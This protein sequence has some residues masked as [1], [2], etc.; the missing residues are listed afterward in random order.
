MLVS[1]QVQLALLCVLFNPDQVHLNC[2]YFLCFV[3]LRPGS[4]NL[5][6]CVG[7]LMSDKFT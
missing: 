6:V 2:L 5:C 3:C 4:H 7:G 1:D